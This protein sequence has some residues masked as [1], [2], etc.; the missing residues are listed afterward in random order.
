MKKIALFTLIGLFLLTLP[1]RAEIKILHQ[2][3]YDGGSGAQPGK[4]LIIS[5]S[6]LYGM[7]RFQGDNAK[8]ML[9]KM[10]TDGTGFTLLHSF[11]GGEEDGQYPSGSLTFSDTTLYGMTSMGG[12]SGNGTI[13][14][15]QTDGT[16]FA[17]LH[18]FIGGAED[19][20]YPYGS[21]ILFGST[22][23]GM[24]SL[25]G[26]SNFGTIFKIQT[27]GSGFALL[28]SFTGGTLDGKWPQGSLIISGTTLFGMTCFGGD[29]DRGTIFKI[30]TDG[31]GFALLHEFIGGVDD[32]QSPE[33]SLLLSGSTLY[34]MTSGGGDNANPHF[35]QA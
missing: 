29:S 35:S 8:G 1:I 6:T 14:M 2:F 22:L 31:T 10:E 11:T 24:T 12:D 27:D 25:G 17:L 7:T 16:S 34:G 32:G 5:N 4:S 13:F 9:F 15:I 26:D 33:G 30:E 18:E 21:L 28:H 19:G 20:A 3:E 23:Y